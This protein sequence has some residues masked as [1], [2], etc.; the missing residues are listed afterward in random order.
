MSELSENKQG[1]K[2][3]LSGHTQI[4]GVIGW[5]IEHSVSPQMHNAAFRAL[6]LDWC[7]VPFPVQPERVPEALAGV[8]A[9]GLRGINATVPHKQAL[10]PLVDERT[11][12]AQAIGAVNTV[13]VQ[14]GRL[15]GHNTD[16]KGFLRALAEAGFEPRGC[17]ALVL[18]A[19]GAARAVIYALASVGA[20]VTILN[21]TPQRAADLAAT[22]VQVNPQARLVAGRLDADRLTR[23]AAGAELVVQTTPLG[24][25]PRV[26]ASPWPEEVPFPPQAFLYD[27]IYN[28]RETQLMRR[29]RQAGAQAENG[30]G[31]L[32]HQGAEAFELWTGVAA[33][34]EVMRAAC[35]A[36]LGGA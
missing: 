15:L 20:Q 3:L 32:V 34:V 25:W 11:P 10:L 6:D 13:I 4:V 27:L 2:P 21:R 19:G 23:A 26:E 35:L 1:C 29:A 28:P 18:G 17:S 22:F 7:Y 36:A 14:G 9:L 8:R 31:M 24:M 5:P 30:L 33:P 12:E 16:A